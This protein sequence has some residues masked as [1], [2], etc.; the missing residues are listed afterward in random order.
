MKKILLVSLCSLLALTATGCT[1]NEQQVLNN[2]DT[3]LT[4]VSTIV[5]STSTT[6]V[7]TVSPIQ[8]ET[9]QNLNYY[10][11]I[12]QNAYLNMM[13][14]EELRQN[15][16]S[17]AG[18]LKSTINKKYKLGKSKTSAIR[19]LTDSLEK[20]ITS[21]ASTKTPV[22]N[23]VYKIQRY[24]GVETADAAKARSSYNELN[25]IMRSRAIYLSNLQS[26]MEEISDLLS[27]SVVDDTNNEDNNNNNNTIRK[28]IDTYNQNVRKQEQTTNNPAPQVNETNITNT[29]YNYQYNNYYNDL[30]NRDYRFNPNRNTDTFY[31]RV[32]NID[33]YR[34]N[35]YYRGN[36]YF[37][38]NGYNY[39]VYPNTLPTSANTNQNE[40]QPKITKQDNIECENCN[41]NCE[42]CKDQC[43]NCDGNKFENLNTDLLENETKLDAQFLSAKEFKK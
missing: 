35:P 9:K 29:P 8:L 20:Y 40:T 7:N 14:E 16:L 3:K 28:N 32:K 2:L 11:S 42:N 36:P 24:V 1:S 17:T 21:L 31:P 10:Q 22:K 12:K 39:D 25:N 19:T 18:Y 15:V 34:Y 4:R 5:S 23:T 30:Y 37:N 6:E 38:N 41:D 27:E 33:T 13:R 43:G 26:T